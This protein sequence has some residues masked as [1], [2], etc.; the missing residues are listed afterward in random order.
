MLK[1][2]GE[3]LTG[4]P[5]ETYVN[6][7]M[8]WGTETEPRAR[9]VYELETGHEVEQ[10]AMV[11]HSDDVACSPDGLIELDGG[12]EIKCP[13]TESHLDTWESQKVPSRY[14]PQIQG[15]MWVTGRD[16]WDFVSYD[17]RLPDTHNLVILR[18]ERNAEYIKRLEEEVEAFA[19]EL[20][21]LE[22]RGIE[23]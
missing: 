13:N 2:L 20:K 12:L 19:Y 17:P 1:L 4:R 10:V 7:A 3:R 16:W 14:I 21:Q 5:G 18:V 8:Q 9:A 15:C 6:E 23:T 11:I 22:L